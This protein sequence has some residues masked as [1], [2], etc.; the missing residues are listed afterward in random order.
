MDTPTVSTTPSPAANAFVARQAIFDKSLDVV[1][2]ELLFRGAATDDAAH[3]TDRDRASMRVLLDSFLDLGLDQL[4]GQLPAFLNLT[5]TFF[6]SAQKMP[7]PRDRVVL[8]LLEGE[9]IDAPLI[10]SVRGYAQSGYRIA[11]DDFEYAPGTEP[12][13]EIA[14]IVKIDVLNLSPSQV[15]E[16]VRIVRPYDAVLLAEKVETTEHYEFCKD[17]GFDLFQGYF[18]CRP[19]VLGGHRIPA[20][21]LATLRLLAKLQD[22]H[23]E[24]EALEKIIREDL[25]LSYKLLRLIN[26]AY[27]GLPQK[28]ESIKQTLVLL[29]LH[30]IRAWVSLLT[31]SSLDDKPDELMA[32]AMIRAKM[33]EQLAERA[34]I[35]SA[36]VYFTAGLFS[37]LDALLDMS[38][39]DIMEQLPLAA[40][41]T[42]ALLD[43][44]GSMGMALDCVVAYERGEWE[45]VVFRA[46]EP[47]DIRGAY[48]EAVEWSQSAGREIGL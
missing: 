18:L 2:Y 45:A 38:M 46:L 31:L 32:T 43:R 26:S 21:R 11:L 14:D 7:L 22:P 3:F 47:H 37:T 19:N 27:Y 34:G 12:L 13:L 25:S 10:E 4:V 36:D 35:L 1:G 42:A 17:L 24:L 16:Q 30:H 28:V 23:V 8:E 9:R 41:L 20:N 48:L 6:L 33:C 39:E 29:G 44:E 40:E 15:E 5:R